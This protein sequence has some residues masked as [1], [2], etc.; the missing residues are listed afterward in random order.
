MKVF[1]RFLVG[2]VLCILALSAG[3][4]I[5]AFFLNSPSPGIPATGKIFTIE[6]GESSDIVAQKLEREGLIRSSLFMRLLVKVQGSG[7]RYRFGS[8]QIKS[9]MTTQEINDLFVTGKQMLVRLTIP[10]GW[11]TGKI[12]RYLA[13]KGACSEQDFLASCVS[14]DLL[15]EFG[16]PGKTMEGYLRPD[17]YFIPKDYSAEEIVKMMARNFF[18]A[19]RQLYPDA[20]GL[21]PQQ[22]FDK[23][24]L[25]SIVE[26]EYRDP[27]EAPEIAS[28]FYNRLGIGMALQSCANVEYVITEVLK[29]PHPEVIY[30]RDLKLKNLY[31]TYMYPGLPPG[32]I[33]NP[34]SIAL[35]AVFF[36]TKTDYWYFRLVD[37]ENG[38]HHFSKTLS[39]HKDVGILYLQREKS[40]Q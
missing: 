27:A 25:A 36:P 14:P 20:S 34:G 28:V 38:R 23:V 39:E 4:F 30:D 40:A 17:T 7:G 2:I 22:L 18:H 35:K 12:A 19:V 24:R 32:P 10:E 8:Y 6:Q 33:S 31:N 1:I 11:T 29:K 5:V 26:R 37:P 16:V 9:G 3:V 13:E 15:K 21:S